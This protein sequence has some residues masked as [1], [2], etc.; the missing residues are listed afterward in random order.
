LATALEIKT[1]KHHLHEYRGQVLIYS[2]L[3]AERFK[4][5]NSDNVL[6]YVMD[7]SVKD[8]FE[9]IQHHKA[10]L[11]ELILGRNELAKWHQLTLNKIDRSARGLHLDQDCDQV[12][13]VQV[14]PMT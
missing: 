12:N 5:A 1:G 8:G 6:L 3:I 2:L 9:Y 11:D 13:V 14:P 7:Q 4:N 10:D